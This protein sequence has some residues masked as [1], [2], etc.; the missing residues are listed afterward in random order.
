VQRILEAAKHR[1]NR[2]RWA[3]ALAL[4]LRQ[5]ECL[6]LK[7]TD[8]DLDSGTLCVRRQ[9]NRPKWAHGCGGTCARKFAGHCPERMALRSET[10][11][12]KSRAGVRTLGLPQ[13]LVTLLREHASDQASERE[14]AGN[15]WRDGGWLFSGPTGRVLS[16]R[17]DYTEWK[18]LLVGAGVRET[19]LHDARHTAA[20]VLLILGVPERAVMS[21]MGWSNT[22]MASRY[23]HLTAGIRADVAQRIDGLIWDRSPGSAE[24]ETPHI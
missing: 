14:A 6:G 23:Q 24:P 21:L 10:D 9:R 22:A 2:C 3:I 13:Q 19:R 7:W 18:R 15:L 8:V 5:G 11:D 12:T 1:R 16:P 20:T 4:G 17:S